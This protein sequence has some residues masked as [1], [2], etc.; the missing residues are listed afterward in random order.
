MKIGWEKYYPYWGFSRCDAFT[1]N[2]EIRFGHLYICWKG[3]R[4]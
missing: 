4:R 3:K 2:Y 1:Y